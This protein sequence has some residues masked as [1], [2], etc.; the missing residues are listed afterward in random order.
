[1]KLTIDLENKTIKLL[2]IVSFRDLIKA[3][4]QLLPNDEWKDYKLDIECTIVNW[5]TPITIPSYPSN[6]IYPFYE[7]I[8]V[9]SGITTFNIEF[10]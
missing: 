3:L 4:D 6:P 5:N 7:T 8:S 9:N 2:E 10:Q 1:M